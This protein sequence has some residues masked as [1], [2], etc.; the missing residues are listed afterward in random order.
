MNLLPQGP[1]QDT[2]RGFSYIQAYHE[3]I[4]FWCLSKR[5]PK[6]LDSADALCEIHGAGYCS[7]L[8]HKNEK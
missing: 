1:L 5:T 6:G 3:T 8:K 2:P 4:S 7:L